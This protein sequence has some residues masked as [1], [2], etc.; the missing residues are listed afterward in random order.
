MSLVKVRPNGQVTLPSSLRERAKLNV[1]DL[2]EAKLEKGKITLTPVVH[3]RDND[4]IIATHG[5][6]VFILDSATALQELATAKSN[7]VFLFDVRPATR[8]Q[9]WAKDSNLGQKTFTAQ[10]PPNGALIDYYLKADVTG[11]IVITVADKTGKTIRTIRSTANKTGVN[12]P[13]G[14]RYPPRLREEVQS[15]MGSITSPIAPPTEPQMLRLRE[16]TDETQK[17][18]AELNGIISGSVRRIN[19]KLSSQPHVVTGSA[20]R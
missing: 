11:P 2:L 19:E 15:L 5:R 16:V 1:G 12:R 17:A 14:Y 18:V 13:F 3:P 20:V 9:M 7:D 8:Y 4:L 6:G 10:N